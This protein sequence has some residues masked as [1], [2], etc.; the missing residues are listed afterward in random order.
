MKTKDM[1]SRTG[2]WLSASFCLIAFNAV[3][4][5]KRLVVEH[6]SVLIGT[7]RG[8]QPRHVRQ[9]LL[10]EYGER[11]HRAPGLQVRSCGHWRDVLEPERSRPVEVSPE[12]GLSTAVRFDAESTVQDA[13]AA[14]A[15]R[16][17]EVGSAGAGMAPSRRVDLE[18]LDALPGIVPA[19]RSQKNHP[20]G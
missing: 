16:L 11:R 3:P 4:G 6:V 8:P 14:A 12:T 5:G 2:R 1:P 10:H 18:T 13:T 17:A 15:E 7:G 20:D 9:R 19:G